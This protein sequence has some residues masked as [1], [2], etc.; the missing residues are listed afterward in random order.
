M[1]NPAERKKMRNVVE[2]V[3]FSI[4]GLMTVR[5]NK[6]ER[7][8]PEEGGQ[9][10]VHTSLLQ[11]FSQDLGSYW[12]RGMRGECVVHS[13]MDITGSWESKAAAD[14]LEGMLKLRNRAEMRA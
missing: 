14:S 1:A 7:P 10:Q 2:E 12:Q 11:P 4:G 9:T 3:S 13:C 6:G 8:E 5:A